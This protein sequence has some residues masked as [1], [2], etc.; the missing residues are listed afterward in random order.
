MFYSLNTF[1]IRCPLNLSVQQSDDTTVF[2]SSEN[3]NTSGKIGFGLP[4][5]TLLKSIA[6]RL[7][8]SN[9]GTKPDTVFETC[10][11]ILDW[12]LCHASH[13]SAVQLR[14][15]QERAQ[16]E[17]GVPS[18]CELREI[19][20]RASAL[21]KVKNEHPVE[22]LHIAWFT[23]FQDTINVLGHP[24]HRLRQLDAE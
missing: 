22:T 23:V 7:P 19:L 14:F 20:H 3:Q 12:L 4:Y 15:Y 5:L 13:I 2:Q 9:R 21:L 24:A 6:L 8:A 10:A 1:F 17:N 18:P 11:R 16:V